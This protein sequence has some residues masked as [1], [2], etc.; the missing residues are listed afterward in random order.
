MRAGLWD[1]NIV[2]IRIALKFHIIL[3]VLYMKLLA[4]L[5]RI[6]RNGIDPENGVRTVNNANEI[7]HYEFALLA[8]KCINDVVNFISP[9]C[10]GNGG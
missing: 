6:D 3:F 8:G 9:G 1:G 10:S 2:S 4:I 5:L 7:A